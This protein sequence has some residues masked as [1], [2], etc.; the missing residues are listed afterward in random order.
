MILVAG[1]TGDLGGAVTRMLLAR[2][3]KLRVLVRPSSPYASLADAGA[4]VAIGDLK[5]RASL[6]A[7][8]RGV[9]TVITTANSARRGGED[10]PQSVDVEGNRN[11]IDAAKAAGVRHFVFVSAMGA[12]PNGPIAFLAAKGKTEE[13]LGASG[14]RYT[15]IAPNAFMEV[16]TS[17]LVGA[18]ARAGQ[19]V[20]LVGEGRRKHSFISA[21][22]VAEYVVAAVSNPAA[23]D[24]RLVLGGPEPL[25]LREVAS[26]YERALGRGVAIRTVRPGEPVPGVP[27][28]LW[29]MVAG[30][31]M[32]DSPVDMSETSRIFGVAP[33]PLAD[34]ARREC[35]GGG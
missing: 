17:M 26:I 23:L 1:G 11:L 25:S 8:C 16:W 21:A 3:E 19:P 27:E 33:T 24:A 7:A 28:S 30:L 18:P 31:D 12:D 4:E 35:A 15:I 29:G 22:D 5:D 34:V 13:Y 10:N 20:T 32:F 9:E 6:D 14:M 2:G